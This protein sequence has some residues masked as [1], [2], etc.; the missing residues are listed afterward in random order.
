MAALQ[1]AR[2]LGADV[3]ATASAGKWDKLRELGLD[4]ERIASSRDLDFKDSFLAATQG[5]GVDVVLNALAGDFVDAALDLLPRGGRFMEMGKTDVRD[6]ERVAAEHRGVRYQAFDLMDAG[7]DRI[8]EMLAEL[9]S[10]FR[11]GA[12]RPLPVAAWPVRRAPEAFRHLSQARHIGKVA[13]TLPRTLDPSGTVL[14]TGATGVL[15]GLLARHLAAEHGVRHLLLAGRRGADSDSVRDLVGELAALGARVTVVACDVSDREALTGL[16]AAV[17]AE[18]P[19]TGVVHAAGVLDDGLVTGLGAG[20]LRR[21]FAPKVNG[22][23][24]L[25]E[26]TRD[27]DLSLFALFS[28]VTATLGNAGQAGYAAANA[29]MDALARR[30]AA[31]GAAATAL[32]WGLWAADSG[33]TRDLGEA[34]RVRLARIGLSPL[35]SERGLELFD[36]AVAT[37]EPF[38]VPMG[39]DTAALANGPAAVPAML[40]GLVG[41]TARARVRRS[42]STA[43]PAARLPLTE[44]FAKL[45]REERDR[46]VLDT[47]RRETAHVL[48]HTGAELPSPDRPFKDIGFDS[49]T[50]VELRNRLDAATGLRLP[51]TLVFDHPTPAAMA[52]HIRRALFP[53]DAGPSEAADP[54]QTAFREL[55]AAIPYERFRTAGLLGLLTDLATDPAATDS[56]VHD[57]TPEGLPGAGIDELDADALIRLALDDATDTSRSDD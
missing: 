42:V 17:P 52:D 37:G 31:E 41:G 3:Y 32:G 48:G 25:H 13:L 56:E 1:L 7:A 20:Q 47:V 18:H 15:G 8:A 40:S 27:L 49:L 38:L 44:R 23:W 54:V 12:L 9:L 5:E 16:L 6:P 57:G 26:L 29:F 55:L 14:V 33:M 39:L 24:L 43:G 22:G 34:D 50:G 46:A 36:L 4:D 19:L 21:V 51:A 35:P 53:D 28:S 2:H 45:G 30:R 11:L 10:L